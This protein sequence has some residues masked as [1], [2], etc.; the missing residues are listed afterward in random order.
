MADAA[1]A[2]VAEV[3]RGEEVVEIRYVFGRFTRIVHWVRFVMMIWFVISGLYIA[4]PFIG[5]DYF[6]PTTYNFIQAQIRGSHIW[7]GWILIA[8]T[9]VRIY[10]FLFVRADGKLG[11]GAELRMGKVLFDW[12][13]WRDQLA[14]YLL[15][16]KE[17][18]KHVYSNY[19]PLQYLVYTVL[20]AM[21]LA[22]GITG[23]IL[24]APYQSAGLAG[25]SANLLRPIEFWLGGLVTVRIVHHWL[26]WGI[27]LFSVI[28]IYMAVWNSIRSRSMLIEAVIS[29]YKVKE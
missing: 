3:R 16:R 27:I 23:I 5:R 13:A 12:R 1:V 6:T 19:G 15:L 28:H 7:L 21:L 14:Y 8:L 10:E 26:M 11:I 22:I 24:A 20:Y 25:F 18:P 2:K 29:G 4:Y 17:H 9:L